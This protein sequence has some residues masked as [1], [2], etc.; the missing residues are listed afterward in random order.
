MLAPWAMGDDAT[1]GARRIECEHSARCGGCP[2]IALPYE[3]Q[4]VQKRA[5]VVGAVTRYPLLETVYTG[6]PLAADPVIGYRTRAK[7][8]VG[9]CGEIGLYARGGGHVVVDVPKCKVLCPIITK[10]AED[11]R[12]RIKSGAL[13]GLRAID[14]REVTPP[15]G[16]T[17]ALVTLVV[18]KC[19]DS[20]RICERLKRA[21]CAILQDIPE[22]IGIAVN[23]QEP[24]SIQVL[25]ADTRLL[26]GEGRALDRVG[27]STQIATFGSFVQ[28]HRT[29][30]SRVHELVVR[31]ISGGPTHARVL[32]LYGGSGAIA[33]AVARTGAEVHL[34]ESFGPAVHAALDAARRAEVALTAE[35][36]DVA[37]S[38][39]AL[40]ERRAHFDAVVVNPPRRGV[41]PVAR[42][43]IARLGAE[44]IVYVSCDPETL[45]RDLDHFTRLGFA[46]VELHPVDMIP[47]TDEVETVAFL[48][49]CTPPPP[50]VVFEDEDIL[51]VDKSPH[52]PTT[53]HGEYE[54]S[55]LARVRTLAP[56]ATPVHRLDIG[57]S[58]LVLFAKSRDRVAPWQAALAAE[59]TRK[60]YLAAARGITQAKGTIVRELREDG[61]SLEART[62]YRRLA[63]AGGHSVL[64]VIPEQGRT[65]QIRRHLAAIQHPVLGDD[66]YGHAATNRFF[67]E[68]LSLD[69]AFLHCVRLE[70]SH[71]NGES[72]LVFES[73]V[74]GDLRGVLERLGGPGTLNFLEQ[75]NALGTGGVSS[76]PPAT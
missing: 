26:A 13:E 59:T 66:R 62:R 50:R 23:F 41:H 15:D 17:G 64:R 71:P 29:Q 75:K 20:D 3:E 19:P 1:L 12:A 42:E 21:A 65:H 52:E 7:L 45:A 51:V 76:I 28:A 49:R 36:G 61:R 58:G 34:I 37:T 73:P 43:Q 6:A 4:L 63:V 2:A 8:M 57:T 48:R 25:G 33:I 54:G 39:Q 46:V 67:E 22:V 70:I 38:V 32:D 40:R 24:N 14:I 18:A 30:T 60:V 72:R 5:R 27:E 55:L 35:H 10:I 9:P 68:K 44:R 69:R 47:L 11:I 53:P 56:D 74:P 31:G 16:K